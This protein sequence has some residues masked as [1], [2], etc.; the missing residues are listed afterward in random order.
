MLKRTLL[1]RGGDTDQRSWGIQTKRSL[2]AVYLML[3]AGREKELGK[4]SN[5][6]ELS[7][8]GQQPRGNKE[9][10]ILF[11][12]SI[13]WLNMCYMRILTVGY[14]FFELLYHSY[15]CVCAVKFPKGH[16][17]AWTVT[18]G[19]V[20]Y[21]LLLAECPSFQLL[22]YSLLGNDKGPDSLSLSPPLSPLGILESTKILHVV[23]G[24]ISRTTKNMDYV[25]KA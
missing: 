6:I 4:I 19:S 12:F 22:P 21:S 11:L 9:K 1:F 7:Q 2:S 14:I 23:S 3:T 8:D 18:V 5:S 17:C 13:G 25:P 16:S 24:K 10:R 20:R 15:H